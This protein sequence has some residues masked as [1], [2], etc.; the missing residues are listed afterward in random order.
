M[1]ILLILIFGYLLGSFPS[2][3]LAGKLVSGID[4]RSVG[5]GSTGATNVLRHIG[6]VPA[7]IVFILDISKGASTVVIASALSFND[8]IVVLAGIAAIAGHIWPIWLNWKGGKAVATGLGIFLG[9]SWQVGLACLG[10]FLLVFSFSKIISLSS[11]IAAT[12]LPII[13][14]FSFQKYNFSFPYLIISL[15]SMIFVLWR[16]RTNIQRLLK[17]KEPRVGQSISIDSNSEEK[18]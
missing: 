15:I 17:G 8:S 16:H 12:S 10:V 1:Q 2:G 7:L 4:L 13:M 18:I 9:L 5:S 14:V 3:Y 11:I 6:K